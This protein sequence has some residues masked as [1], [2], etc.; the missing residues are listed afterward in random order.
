MINAYA[1][2]ASFVAVAQERLRRDDHDGDEADHQAVLD[3]GGALLL[4]A[5]TLLGEELGALFTSIT[6]EL[7]DAPAAG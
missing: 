5:V 2:I 7:P 6:D 1:T 4:A 3:G